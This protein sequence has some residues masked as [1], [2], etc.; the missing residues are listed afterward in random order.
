MKRI[1]QLY[2]RPRGEYNLN[3]NNKMR[4]YQY[5][6]NI[7]VSTL[8]LAYFGAFFRCRESYSW[9]AEAVNQFVYYFGQWNK[10]KTRQ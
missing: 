5:A 2:K 9:K 3:A 8:T 10:F 7:Y 4:K 6:Q 1:A